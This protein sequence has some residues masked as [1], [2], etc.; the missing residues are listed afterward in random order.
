M[1]ILTAQELKNKLEESNLYAAQ[2][3]IVMELN[4]TKVT[5]KTTDT[6]GNIIQ[7]WL[8]QW[9][10]DNNIYHRVP[11]NTQNF[12]DFYLSDS[13]ITELMEVK[14]YFASRRPAFDVAN[15]DS[16]WQS[17]AEAPHRLDANYLIFAY[18]M[19][20]GNLSIRNIY[21]KKVWELT[22][23]ASAYPLN[24]QRKNGQ[25]YNIRPNSFHSTRATIPTFSS[26]EEFIGALYN[27]VLGHTNR[28]TDTRKWLNQVIEGYK[29]FSGYDLKANIDPYISS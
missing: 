5:I 12:P 17:L 29:N 18:D 15:F 7:E 11:E 14:S 9:L 24:C 10:K 1:D 16:Y 25:I 20:D 23:K 3:Q 21:L 22:G 2:G 6:I 26:K 13:N 27:T 4:G 19:V 28:A 8:S